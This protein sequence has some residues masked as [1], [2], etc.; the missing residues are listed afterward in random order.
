M[1]IC[2]CA[3]EG[4]REQISGLEKRETETY[5]GRRTET[6]RKT[7]RYRERYRERQSETE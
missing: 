6:E 4:N 7:E 2:C 1:N 3:W 5:R